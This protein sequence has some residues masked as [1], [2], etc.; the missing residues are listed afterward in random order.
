MDDE[1]QLGF[2]IDEM[3]PSEAMESVI[4]T[5]KE[6]AENP[7]A[8][9]N[10]P[11]DVA[12]YHFQMYHPRYESLIDKLSYKALKR[13]AKG[14]VIYPLEERKFQHTSETEKEALILGEKLLQSKFIMFMLSL[15]EM[16]AK[17]EE[18]ANNPIKEETN[19]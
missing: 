6:K 10:N 18:N 12:A 15:N 7:Q 4:D 16:A 1:K 11:E 8:F 3:K 14:L 17:A 2:P 13:L 9:E 19:G 5:T